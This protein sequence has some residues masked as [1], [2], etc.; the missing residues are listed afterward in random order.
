A[1]VQ[2]TLTESQA[3]ALVAEKRQT[4]RYR[5]PRRFRG[6]TCRSP[7]VPAMAGSEAL[8]SANIARHFREPNATNGASSATS[9]CTPEGAGASFATT[10]KAPRIH[11]WMRQKYE[12][13]PG[14]RS[15]GVEETPD[16]LPFEIGS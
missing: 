15:G 7:R 8:G 11:G 16:G 5:R 14:A 6:S 10:S 3:P 4:A 12:Y 13:L 1:T 9:G 2:A